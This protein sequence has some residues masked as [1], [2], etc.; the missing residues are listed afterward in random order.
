MCFQHACSLCWLTAK[1]RCLK[2][3]EST[4]YGDRRQEQSRESA[5]QDPKPAP[6]RIGA[7]GQRIPPKAHIPDFHDMNFSTWPAHNS[8]AWGAKNLRKHRLSPTLSVMGPRYP[9]EIRCGTPHGYRNPRII[10]SAVRPARCHSN[11]FGDRV[12]RSLCGSSGTSE[13]LWAPEHDFTYLLG[14][15]WGLVPCDSGKQ[16]GQGPEGTATQIHHTSPPRRRAQGPS[17]A[18]SPPS[19]SRFLRRSQFKLNNDV[20]MRAG[21]RDEGEQQPRLGQNRSRLT[22]R[23]IAAVAGT[24][25]TD[26]GHSDG[27]SHTSPVRLLEPK[28][29]MAVPFG[30]S[31]KDHLGVPGSAFWPRPGGPSGPP[32]LC[33]A[34]SMDAE[35][36]AKASCTSCP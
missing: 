3:K 30:E 27:R 20:L 11:L 24:K 21:G 17:A 31:I 25:E 22:I 10:K 1:G 2:S 35:F 13:V 6:C 14:W 33:C 12:S 5:C 18:T 16:C 7:Q 29:R 32:R 36:T 9:R 28:R 19:G 15:G 8:R 34:K 23:L 26:V 4:S